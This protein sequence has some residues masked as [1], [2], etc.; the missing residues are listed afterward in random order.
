MKKFIAIGQ[1]TIMPKARQ[2]E[3]FIL[4]YVRPCIA[5]MPIV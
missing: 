4:R 5:N 3:I 2:R 1:L